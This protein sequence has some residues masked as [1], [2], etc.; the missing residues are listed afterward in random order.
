MTSPLLQRYTTPAER[1]RGAV[2]AD[3]FESN[4][5]VQLNEGVL[6][7]T[8]VV[9]NG[10]TFDGVDNR[11]TYSPELQTFDA[12]ELSIVIEFTPT[13]SLTDGDIRYFYAGDTTEYF[14]QKQAD[15]TLLL[16]VGGV[17][18]AT[19]PYATYSP[20]WAA[21]GRNVLVISSQTG[22]TDVYLNGTQIL[23]SDASAYTPSTV[24]SLVIG[25]LAAGGAG[26]TGT[27]HNFSIFQAK[28][29]EQEALD[30]YNQSTWS[31]RNSSTIHL[32]MRASEN[33]ASNSPPR[34][35]DVSGNAYHAEFG[36]GVAAAYPTKLDRRGY[37]LDGGDH[38]SIAGALALTPRLL[39]VRAVVQKPDCSV[40][41]MIVA[42]GDATNL[43]F[44]L[45]TNT[46]GRVGFGVGGLLPANGGASTHGDEPGWLHLVGTYDGANTNLY[47][48][49]IFQDAAVTPLPP[50]GAGQVITIGEYYDGSLQYTGEILSTKIWTDRALTPLQ[51]FDDYALCQKE[52][53]DV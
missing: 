2:W 14:L 51:I 1:L 13:F 30:F 12:A 29:T 8:P 47:V 33:D 52:L 26:F 23:T 27:I 53:R 16:Q 38:M 21:D 22:D 3:K 9:N 25:N 31:Y 35:L 42:A 34:T 40:V 15:N 36:G 50:A 43:S 17:A 19:I 48:N 5:L 11:I 10:A 32:P 39:T 7:D 20:A 37:D 18:I 24:T 45:A 41:S 46:L 4:E 28:L 6:T 49:G 44:A